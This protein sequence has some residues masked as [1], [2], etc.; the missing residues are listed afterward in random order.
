MPTYVTST[1]QQTF[2]LKISKNGNLALVHKTEIE[3]SHDTKL[4]ARWR[5][6]YRVTESAQSLGTD[7]LAELDGAELAGWIHSSWLKQW[8][9][10][11]EGVHSTWEIGIPNT[12]PEEESEEFEEFE[13]EAVPGP[14]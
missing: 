7:Q 11:N 6:P 13:A 8:F 3:Q 1:K 12:T 4:D 10:H 5:G 14:K 2:K 9:T